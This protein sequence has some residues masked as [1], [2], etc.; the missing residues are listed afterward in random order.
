MIKKRKLLVSEMVAV[1]VLAIMIIIAFPLQAES[2]RPINGSQYGSLLVSM[3]PREAN[4][5]GAQWRR[6]GTIAW[7]DHAYT[8]TN[9]PIGTH[10]VEFKD[11]SGWIT[12]EN[13]VVTIE[14]GQ[15]TTATGIYI[16]TQ[17]TNTLD[18]KSS[19]A[20]NISIVA[21]PPTYSGIT[22]YSKTNISSDTSITLI[23][24]SSSMFPVLLKILFMFVI[25]NHFSF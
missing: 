24:P 7:Q 11:I 20:S 4:D 21:N 12:P 25:I 17:E 10:T 3:Q 13:Q 8:E 18:V 2:E 14:E 22:N 1:V 5:A 9:V 6:T 19:G 23:A 16:Y 15:A